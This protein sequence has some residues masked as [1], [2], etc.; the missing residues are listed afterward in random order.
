MYLPPKT[1]PELPMVYSSQQQTLRDSPKKGFELMT[2]SKMLEF[3]T[4]PPRAP[5]VPHAPLVDNT[6][7]QREEKIPLITE[8]TTKK[9]ILKDIVSTVMHI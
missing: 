2:K 8:N 6:I 3:P 4:E 1:M 5:L 7:D 9:K